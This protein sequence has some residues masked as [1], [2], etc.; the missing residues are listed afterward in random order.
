MGLPDFTDKKFKV[1]D[2]ILIEASGRT[3]EIVKRGH[4]HQGWKV[5]WDEPMFGVTE[6]WVRTVHM[7][8]EAV[9]SP[10]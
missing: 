10:A 7:E 5:R 8:H 9:D 3:G 4:P 1:G 6:G 2:R